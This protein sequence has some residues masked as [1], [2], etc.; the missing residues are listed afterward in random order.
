LL[1]PP[2]AFILRLAFFFH[3]ALPLLK[4]VGVLSHADSLCF[5]GVETVTTNASSAGIKNGHSRVRLAAEVMPAFAGLAAYVRL[6]AALRA[7]LLPTLASRFFGFWFGRSRGSQPQ[8]PRLIR[9]LDRALGMN[10]SQ[11]VSR[12][13]AHGAKI[14]GRRRYN[15]YGFFAAHR[16]SR[17]VMLLA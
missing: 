9:L 1:L 12:F 14:L 7:S 2:L 3:F 11:G 16:C 13:A 17:R 8:D 15:D 6:G 4:R 10:A 5:L